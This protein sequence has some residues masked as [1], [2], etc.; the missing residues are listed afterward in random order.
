MGGGYPS[1]VQMGGYPSQ[2]QMGGPP[3]MSRWGVPARSRQGVVP[4]PGPDGGYLRW[5]IPPGRTTEGVL[6]T[7]R[8]VYLLRSLRRIFL[9]NYDVMM[10]FCVNK[11]PPMTATKS[12]PTYHKSA[13]LNYFSSRMLICQAKICRKHMARNLVSVSISGVFNITHI[14]QITYT[15]SSPFKNYCLSKIL[16]R[17]TFRKPE[18]Q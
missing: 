6:A 15:Q 17:C 11:S 8:A 10:A 13:A 4:R 7:R 12:R 9:F 2:I 14:K 5:V 16:S 3:A 1:Q 18:L